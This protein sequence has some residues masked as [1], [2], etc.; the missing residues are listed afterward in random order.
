MNFKR[1]VGFGGRVA[2]FAEIV[3]LYIQWL[4]VLIP[5][6]SVTLLRLKHC[7]A[8]VAHTFNPSTCEAEAGG[9]LSLRPAWSTK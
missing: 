2:R 4:P 1:Y 7:W 3:L 8:V 9:F 5:F 6:F